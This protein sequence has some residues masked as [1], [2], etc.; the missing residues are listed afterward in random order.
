M[1]AHLQLVV[2]SCPPVDTQ[3]SAALTPTSDRRRFWQAFLEWLSTA[4]A[5]ETEQLERVLSQHAHHVRPLVDAVGDA[6]LEPSD[7]ALLPSAL[8]A[9]L[10]RHNWRPPLRAA[11]T[12]A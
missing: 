9:T 3:P 1:K 11:V 8:L 12:A 10:S 2:S 5:Q 4:S 7:A 6:L